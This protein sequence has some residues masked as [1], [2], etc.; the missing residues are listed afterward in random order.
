M[1]YLYK[2]CAL[3]VSL[4]YCRIQSRYAMGKTVVA[5]SP[6]KDYGQC[7][8]NFKCTSC[9]SLAMTDGET[10]K[11]MF[12]IPGVVLPWITVLGDQWSYLF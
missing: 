6:T 2:S 11:K 9:S 8:Y 10:V 12:V 4:C 7:K 5:A 3:L 1:L